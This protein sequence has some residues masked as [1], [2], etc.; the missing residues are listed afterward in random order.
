MHTLY[1]RYLRSGSPTDG[2]VIQPRLVRHQFADELLTEIRHRLFA[3]DL[4]F[5][6][7][8]TIVRDADKADAIL[9]GKSTVD[10]QLDR[11]LA[12]SGQE[13]RQACFDGVNAALLTHCGRYSD[14]SLQY[15]RTVFTLCALYSNSALDM[16]NTLASFC[17]TSA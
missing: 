1:Y 8:R 16:I 10:D 6:I 13:E 12:T 17:Q 2:R 15:A 7:A 11:E 9:T 5:E 14:Y 3:D 4:F